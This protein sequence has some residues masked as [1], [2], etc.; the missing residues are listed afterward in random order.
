MSG[1]CGVIDLRG[2]PVEPDLLAR[3]ARPVAHRG[4]DG[5]RTAAHGGAA[6]C[7]LALHATPEAAL[8][9]QPLWERE[10]GLLLAAD[11]RLDA[12]EE[13]IAALGLADAGPLGDAALL[14]AAY[15]RWGEGFPARL[16][17]D[18][19]F[20]LWDAPAGRLLCACDPLGVKPLHYA[21]RGPLLLFASE[22]RQ[23][24]EHP[25]VSP[26][27]DLET[28][29]DHLLGRAEAPGRTFFRGILR[30]PPAHRLVASRLGERLE[31]YWEIDPGRRTVYREE[32]D[33]AAHL[34]ELLDRA[35]R[36]RLRSPAPVVGI[37]MS[38]GLDSGSV[39]ALARRAQRAGQGPGLLAASFTFD[40]LG[41][42]DE[43]PWIEALARELG[44][45]VSRIAAGERWLLAG[46]EAFRPD[47]E[48]PFLAWE[49]CFRELLARVRGRGA[50]VLLT[51]H[52]GDGLLGGSALVYLDRLRRG[53]PGA[54]LDVVRQARQHGR[55]WRRAL[56]RCFGEPLL[57]EA[58]RDAL[59]RLAGRPVAPAVPDWIDPEFARRTGLA[60]RLAPARAPRRFAEAARQEIH[61]GA[62][63]RDDG[64][65][66][67]HWYDRGAARHGLEVRHPFLDRRLVELV[68]SIPPEQLFRI[69]CYKPLLRRA[70]E[71][72]LP[73]AVLRRPA[74]ARLD[75][76][77]EVSL[78]EKSR[79]QVE[80]L[81]ARPLAA[82]WGILDAGRLR[83]AYRAYRGGAGEG[84]ERLWYA[85]TLENWFREHC[86]RLIE[87]PALETTAAG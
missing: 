86:D 58:A 38:G 29:G 6:F 1:L 70:M 23:L 50:R 3:M 51:G 60:G 81:L 76:Y 18:F 48:T 31:P 74:K 21:R 79:P 78:R 20:A 80:A 5:M 52:G 61:D 15:R 83:A 2:R 67:L 66:V 10:R 24:L 35:V 73:Q 4:P 65:G 63:G 33:Y 64:C 19:A 25:E 13:L 27:L 57:P 68:V 40:G 39:A 87:S 69:G 85:L 8:D 42:C 28:V 17:G 30:L 12:R 32:G 59:R 44:L 49:S 36:D 14:L 43:G 71:G 84:P 9:V 7:H 53:R 11:V 72:L 26:E 55:D 75:G 54:V 77:V 34:G 45:E 46:E 62:L 16:L 82:E 41:D 22:A 56:Y 47:L 37:A